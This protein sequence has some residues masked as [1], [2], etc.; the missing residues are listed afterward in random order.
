MTITRPLWTQD[1]RREKDCKDTLL[2]SLEEVLKS[3]HFMGVHVDRAVKA[4]TNAKMASKVIVSTLWSEV[5]VATMWTSNDINSYCCKTVLQKCPMVHILQK[6][7]MD[8]QTKMLF[9]HVTAWATSKNS[10]IHAP[11]GER[12]SDCSV[13]VVNDCTSV[14]PVGNHYRCN[15]IEKR[16]RKVEGCE[17]QRQVG[18]QKYTKIPSLLWNPK[19]HYSVHKRQP[20]VP[21]VNQTNPVYNT[22]YTPVS[23]G[24]LLILSPVYK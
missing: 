11:S 14:I 10:Y 19:C 22:K 8:G 20:P 7:H 15:Q 2:C 23:L 21:V 9:A 6:W 3:R 12:S 13:R 18:L 17:Y 5:I 1:N 24:S 16:R 4:I